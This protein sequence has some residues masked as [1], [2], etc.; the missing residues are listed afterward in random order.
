MHAYEIR[1]LSQGHTQMVVTEIYLSDYAAVRAG[2]KFAA[3]RA[4]E[5]WRGSECVYDNSHIPGP[6]ERGGQGSFATDIK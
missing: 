2:Q 3:G 6:S 1:V 5:V 4:F